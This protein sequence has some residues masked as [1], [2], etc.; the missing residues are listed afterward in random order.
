VHRNV[1]DIQWTT[2]VGIELVCASTERRNASDLTIKHG[3][4]DLY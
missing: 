1:E 2:W 4:G 3:G